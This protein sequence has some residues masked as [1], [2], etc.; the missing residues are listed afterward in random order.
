MFGLEFGLVDGMLVN[1]LT[2]YQRH[3]NPEIDNQWCPHYDP[4]DLDPIPVGIRS[5]KTL[6]KF[7]ASLITFALFVF[8]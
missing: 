8:V 7:V 6:L 2:M 5:I 3:I 4:F 1:S